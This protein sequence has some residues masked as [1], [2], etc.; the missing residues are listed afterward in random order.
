MSKIKEKKLPGELTYAFHILKHPKDTYFG[1]K[2]EGR[3]SYLSATIIFLI[4]IIFYIIH[5]YLQGYLFKQDFGK[6]GLTINVLTVVGVI[7]LYVMMNFLISTLNDGEGK[8]RDIYVST[9]N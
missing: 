9:I 7:I 2:R 6:Q 3:A 1:I 4:F 8:F 5:Q